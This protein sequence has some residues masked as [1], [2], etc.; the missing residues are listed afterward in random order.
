MRGAGGEVSADV[1]D[2]GEGFFEGL[3]GGGV[4]GGHLLLDVEA[5]GGEIA[6]DVEE[7]AGDDVSDSADDGE[8]D[9]AGDGDG[10]DAGKRGELRG[11]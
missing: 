10:D 3:L 5:V 2:G 7:L 6:G 9:D 4:D 8:G 11:G 1:F